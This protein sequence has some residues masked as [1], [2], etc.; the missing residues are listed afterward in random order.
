MSA[1]FVLFYIGHL[2]ADYPL[3]TDRQAARKAQ[4]GAAG[5]RANLTH[6]AT[7]L[8]TSTAM[9]TL[10]VMLLDLRVDVWTAAGA[11]AWIAGTHAIIDRRWPIDWW[12]Q[13][14]G[15]SMWAANGGAA[16]VDQTAHIT[17]L[18]IAALAIAAVS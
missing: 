17:A 12:M 13:H 7:H 14:T 4:S 11:L 16:H 5:W 3:Q 18:G 1:L 6:A 2:L 15:Q 9:L 8:A 10:G